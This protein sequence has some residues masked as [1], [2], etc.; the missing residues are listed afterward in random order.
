MVVNDAETS[1][2]TSGNRQTFAHGHVT[3][4]WST[5]SSTIIMP[6][7]VRVMHQRSSPHDGPR[8]MWKCK[9]P[10]PAPSSCIEEGFCLARRQP[11]CPTLCPRSPDVRRVILSG[12][13]LTDPSSSRTRSDL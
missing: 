10:G 13:P 9:S 7:A 1:Q 11:F 8:L 6:I 5:T 4:A 3:R 12:G 2:D